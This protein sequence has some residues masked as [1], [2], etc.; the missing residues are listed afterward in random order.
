MSAFALAIVMLCAPAHA[1]RGDQPAVLVPQIL[2]AYDRATHADDVQ[3]IETVGTIAGSGLT[4][5]FHSWRD[6]ENERDDE[7]LGVRRETSLK[8]GSRLFVRDSSGNVRELRGYLKRRSLT[9]DFIDSGAFLKAPERSKFLG[10]G[11]VAGHRAWRLEVNA[12]GGEPQTMWIET[13]SGLPA[14]LEYLDGDGPTTIDRSD[15]RDVA[16][17]KIAFRS[18]VSDGE[19]QF[20]QTEITTAVTIDKPIEATVFAP[21][22]NRTLRADG[23][24]TVPLVAS[25]QHIAVKVAINDRPLLFLLDTGAQSV[26]LDTNV[27]KALNLPE[28]GALEV[29][30]ATRAGGLH[31]LTVPRITIGTGA[32]DDLVATSL[33]LQGASGGAVRLDGILG[34]PF[35][36]SSLVE[37]DFAHSAMRFGA[38]GSFAPRGVK[39]ELDLDRGLVE[40][41]FVVNATVRAPFIVDTGNS[42][43]LL[44]YR[45]FIDRY[46]GVVPRSTTTALNFGIGGSTNTYRTALD[47]LDLGGVALYHRVV[48]VV[49][50]KK[51]AFGDQVDAG[52]VGLGVLR[53]F[54]V[55]FDL[56]NSAMYLE[57]GDA[58]DDGR[59][60]AVTTSP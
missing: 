48:D 50:T 23:V 16:G 11:T 22:V 59:R 20:D 1:S 41:P 15:W 27:A 19:R 25:G 47:A 13:D 28:A 37:L 52:N 38:P 56:A 14:R 3:T 49:L 57:K 35:F 10:Y 46:P 51:G 45:A 54:V 53:N 44:L 2:A 60:R 9:G 36:A 30:G 58:F 8:L 42:G 31:I 43:E 55:T 5:A 39:V 21:L 33:D 32:L 6:G 29:R 18:V 7:S 24:Q 17:H 26:L 12:V 4:G 34:Y 40:A